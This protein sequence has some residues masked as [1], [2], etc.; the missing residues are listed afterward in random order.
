M[1]RAVARR[2]ERDELVVDDLHDLLAGR[3]AGED[4]GPDR[5]L[6]D[7]RDEVLDDLEVDVRL[8]QRQADLAHRGID[9]GLADPAAAGQGAERLAQPLA[10][11]VEHGSGGDSR[12]VV[13]RIV[14][15]GTEARVGRSGWCAGSDAPKRAQCTAGSF[16]P[17]LGRWSRRVHPDTARSTAPP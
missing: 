10:E 16:G 14:E 8:E 17:P 11:G 1:E 5:P 3:Q 2:Q 6:A 13:I 15:A 9:V 12:V 7:A 4:V